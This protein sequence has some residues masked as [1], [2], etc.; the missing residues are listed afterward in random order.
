MKHG[1]ECQEETACEMECLEQNH[2]TVN[3]F[4]YC[5]VRRRS[6]ELYVGEGCFGLPASPDHQGKTP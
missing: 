3:T 5:T 1:T 2:V 6:S 4:Y